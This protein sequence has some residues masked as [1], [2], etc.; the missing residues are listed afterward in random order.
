MGHPERSII[1][2]YVLNL[3]KAP[4]NIANFVVFAKFS[5]LNHQNIYLTLF[6]KLKEP[7]ILRN[8]DKLPHF[9]VKQNYF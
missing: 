2:N 9:K 4:D 7:Y 3:V 5:R 8:S 1:V 6:L